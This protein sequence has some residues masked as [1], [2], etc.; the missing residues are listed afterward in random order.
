MSEASRQAVLKE[1]EAL[2]PSARAW[3]ASAVPSDGPGGNL[4]LDLPS[5]FAR[6][7]L[8]AHPMVEMQT[9]KGKI[10]VRLLPAE[11]PVHVYRF[12]HLVRTGFY[13]GLIFHEVETGRQVAGGDPRGDGWGDGGFLLRDELY[14][15]SVV[16]GAVCSVQYGRDAG[17]CQFL[18]AAGHRPELDGVATVFGEVVEGMDVVDSLEPGDVIKEITER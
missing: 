11:A 7:A 3:L 8:S 6:D 5:A 17:G 10:R 2:S 4:L 9:A 1:L 16:R 18:I 14:P 12:R 15:R 13:N